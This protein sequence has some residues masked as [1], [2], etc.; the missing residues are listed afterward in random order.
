MRV[1]A[2]ALALLLAGCCGGSFT[3]Q[4]I[5]RSESCRELRADDE[6]APSPTPP[7]CEK[8]HD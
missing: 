5:T 2:F 3:P 7:P 8:R 1:V 6:P 4:E